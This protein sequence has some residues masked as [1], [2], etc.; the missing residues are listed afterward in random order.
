[1]VV[2]GYVDLYPPSFFASNAYWYVM[3]HFPCGWRGEFPKGQLVIY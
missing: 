1:M 2:R 3:G